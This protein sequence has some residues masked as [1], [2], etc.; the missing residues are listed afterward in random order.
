MCRT[1]ILTGLF[2]TVV[3]IG[4]A[5]TQ[6][7]P[8]ADVKIQSI[9]AVVD[10]DGFKCTVEVQSDNDDDARHVKLVMLFPL[11]VQ[12][13]AL[14]KGCTAGPAFPAQGFARCGLGT[15]AVGRVKTVSITTTA[16]TRNRMCAAFVSNDLPD[17]NPA[18]NFGQATA[19]PL[20][21]AR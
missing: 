1:V 3:G 9:N 17:P 15:M 10:A 5:S 11:E 14:P 19:A 7:I 20:A 18:N 2:V 4:A 21:P 13:V 8:A 12:I 16:P 6:G